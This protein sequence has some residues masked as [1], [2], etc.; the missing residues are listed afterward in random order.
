[1][2]RCGIRLG[3]NDP[4]RRFSGWA[5]AAPVTVWSPS[6]E[7]RRVWQTQEGA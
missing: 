2:M 7:V 5:V 1:M 3:D 4:D 6:G